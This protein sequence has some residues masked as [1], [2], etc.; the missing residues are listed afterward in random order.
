MAIPRDQQEVA[1]FL[2]RLAGAAPIET[3]ISLVF[4][5]SDTV[6][7]L[8]KAVKLPFLDFSGVE[9]RR[10]FTE[11]ELALNQRAAPGLYR[12]MLPVVRKPD[13]SLDLASAATGAPVVGGVVPDGVV[14]DW[15][16]RMARVPA[17]DF[18]DAIAARGGLTPGLLDALADA[19]AAYHQSLPPVADVVPPM[20][21]IALGNIPSALGAGLPADQVDAWRGAILAALDAAQPLLVQRARAGLVRRAHGDLHLGNLCLW[22]GRPAPFDAL[23][24]DE[25]LATI[26]L[27]YDLAF[28]LM[29]LDRRVSRAAAN[30]VMNRY[31]A[32]TGDA[33]LV[34]TL[35]PFLSLRAMV[36][37]HVEARSG[38]ADAWQPYL[39][40]AREYLRPAGTVMVVAVG[41]LP[42]SGKSTL[43]RVLAPGLGRAPG[44]LIL[45]SDEIRKRQHGVAPEQ[46]LPQSAYSDAAS[47][48]VFATLADGV[49]VAASGGQCVV[50]DGTFMDPAHRRAVEAAAAAP[51]ARFHGFWLDA[52]LAEL[53]RRVVAR[54]GDA[55]DATV[56]V[57]RS[58]ARDSPG[59][60][61]WYALASLRPDDDLAAARQVLGQ[62]V[63]WGA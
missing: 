11:R 61:G 62:P 29:D 63:A 43:A 55:S 4:V 17:E 60:A 12:D 34:A 59:A 2:A 39:Q 3:H 14:L 35:P 5:G 16:L 38:H 8:K 26:D 15:V 46:R 52:P 18:L 41:G 56:S 30:R 21:E 19:V 48:A 7:K 32:R 13:R 1:A 54:S 28:L 31:V 40:A 24:F 44:A 33:G 57:L 53:E 23:E 9:D 27:G 22:R 49:R 25:T 37:A 50:A 47:E 42:G 20:R 36:R 6:W 51:G 10:R 45:R 58:A